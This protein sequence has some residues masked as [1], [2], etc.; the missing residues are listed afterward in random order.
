MGFAIIC[1]VLGIGCVAIVLKGSFFLA[2]IPVLLMIII[3][4][5]IDQNKEEDS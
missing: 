3:G 4:L 2:T 1:F 5:K